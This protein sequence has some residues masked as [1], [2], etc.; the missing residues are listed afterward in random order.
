MKTINKF[1]VVIPIFALAMVTGSSSAYAATIHAT[2]SS[3]VPKQ[4]A[5]M[6]SAFATGTISLSG[7]NTVVVTP[8]VLQVKKFTPQS[9]VNGPK[10]LSALK[11]HAPQSLPPQEPKVQS[12]SPV[13]V[14]I[15]PATKIL[16]NG[17]S[18]GLSMK[19]IPSGATVHVRYLTVNG[20]NHA[21]EVIATVNKGVRKP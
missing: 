7:A 8:T 11:S 2:G 15:D 1:L 10:T 19:D 21:E 3:H 18:K 5:F 4:N 12:Q 9:K 16:L 14:E 13:T 6:N 17:K 20:V